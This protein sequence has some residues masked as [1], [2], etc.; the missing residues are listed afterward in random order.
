MAIYI[1]IKSERREM[2]KE[3]KLQHSGIFI[4]LLAVFQLRNSERKRDRESAPLHPPV[5]CLPPVQ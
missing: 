4:T 3:S 1:Y 2:E 5:L